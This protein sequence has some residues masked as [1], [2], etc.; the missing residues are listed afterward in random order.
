MLRSQTSATDIDRLV[1]TK[2]YELL[3]SM[4]ARVSPQADSQGGR[5]YSSS[6]YG[7]RPGSPA[8][9]PVVNELLT[10]ELEERTAA[11]DEAYQALDQQIER[12]SRPGVFIGMDTSIYVTH[13]NKLEDLDIGQLVN[14]RED[15]YVLVPM[16]V[17]EELDGLKQRGDS[18][19]RWR[20]G[21]CQVK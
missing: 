21:S 6:E 1:L 8:P 9:H 18:Q 5:I 17:I 15:I 19:A 14:V 16:V 11:F 10:T 12:W 7:I 20:A 4:I 2:R 13:P 3:L